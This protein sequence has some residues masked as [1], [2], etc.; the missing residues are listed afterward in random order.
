MT[1]GGANPFP[2][3]P[4]VRTSDILLQNG[5]QRGVNPR[6]GGAQD[7]T[8]RVL[9]SSCFRDREVW[10]RGRRDHHVVFLIAAWCPI[11]CGCGGFEALIPI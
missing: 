11:V 8:T 10:L 6:T 9:T 5:G 3:V 2:G 4:L 1:W 7:A